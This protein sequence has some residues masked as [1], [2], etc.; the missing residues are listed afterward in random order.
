MPGSDAD[1]TLRSATL[2]V[3]VDRDEAEPGAGEARPRGD[4]AG[5]TTAERR[6]GA[7][8]DAGSGAAPG[9]VIARRYRLVEPLGAGAH[10]EVWTAEDL[11]LGRLVALKWLRRS[12]GAI[13]A[14]VRRE[15]AA[16][17]MLRVPGVVQL[18]DEGVEGDRAFLVMERVEGTPFPGGVAPDAAPPSRRAWADVAAPALAL[19]EVLAR[20]HAAG[21]VHRD[22]KP[23]NVL[24]DAEGRPTV[25]DFG[26]SLWSAPGAR[27]TEA[28]QVLGTPLYL[29]PEQLVGAAVDGRADLYA[30]GMMLY[31]ALTGRVPHEADDVR[32]L[33][34]AR[35]SW[36]AVPIQEVDPGIPAPLAEV[37]NRLLARRPEDRFRSA[38][39]VLIALRGGKVPRRHGPELPRLGGPAPLR[40]V[41]EAARARRP[42]DVVGP[43]GAGRSRCLR[44]AGE[45][46]E[47]AGLR[48]VWL[49]SSRAPLGSLHALLGAMDEQ[50]A[51]RLEDVTAWAAG[52]LRQALD[53]GVVIVADDADRLDPWSAAILERCR[54]GGGAL[55]R[56]FSGAAAGAA[57][58]DVVAL[59]PLDEAALRP[60]FAG[61]D[62]LFHL[63]EDAART[64]WERTEGFPARVEAELTL[65]LRLGLA[66]WDGATL[67]VE[68]EALDPLR[69]GLRETT[70]A[71][72]G[73]VLEEEPHLGE[74]LRWLAVA[75]HQL[76]LEQLAAAM[77]R[78]LW[79]VEAECEELVRRGVARRLSGDRVEPLGQV[80]VTWPV[81]R[82]IKA[83]R[84]IAGVLR[85]G[86]EGRL[87]H[88]LAA[89]EE[90]S[91]AREAIE[92]ARVRA[93]AGM[94]GQAAAALGEALLVAR[95]Q[96]GEASLGAELGIL[97][98]WVKI[99]FAEGTPRAMDRVLYELSRAAA[100]G[101]EVVRLEL[102]V[103]AALSGMG[104]RGELARELADG[105]AP[106][107][108]AELERRRHGVR[109]AAAARRAS[110]LM[111]GQALVEVDAWAERDEHPMARLCLVEGRARLRYVEGRFDEAA[112]LHVEAAASE[113][114]QTGRIAA[115]LSSASA[116]LEAFRH[117]EAAARA[118]AARDLAARCRNP[119]WEG[120]AEW[121]LRSALYRMGET[122]DPDL[123]L[124][125]ATV[126][127]GVPQLEALVCLTEAA[128]A[129]RAE[130]AAVAA[131]LAGRAAGLWRGMDRASG[132]LLSRCLALAA[133]VRA[134]EG[135]VEELA[136]AARA[137]RVPGIGLQALGLLGRA[138]PEA[139]GGLRGGARRA[140]GGDPAGAVGRADGC[141][142]GRGGVRGGGRGGDDV[143]G[144]AAA[145]RWRGGAGGGRG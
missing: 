114:W 45:A 136:E 87:F 40:A 122:G 111:L 32:A 70:P 142:V 35:L 81:A 47:Q 77:E 71:A 55:V 51:R 25:L 135:E 20:V 97:S 88:L 110:P 61:P 145:C 68:R 95:R 37:I 5:A 4:G 93:S 103:Q 66:R 12:A 118:E 100:R 99:A 80:D 116:L 109:I 14:R 62:R 46:L 137:C 74:L 42:V 124:V 28:G 15:V 73:Q 33:L 131:D 129:Y 133:G 106:F 91:A 92:V 21:I 44:D 6:D 86:Q 141:V 126:R 43:P 11:V 120:R 10:G 75:G 17:R 49:L 85:P 41:V 119:Y 82:R 76:D 143:A 144:A 27:L 117:R 36:P 23:D 9:Q 94:L 125:E 50:S 53:D 16:L 132:A 79:K 26:I 104:P 64:L 98:A 140:G 54:A 128:V 134:D 19:F 107:E 139:R 130:Q 67:A 112:A 78:P 22:L 115:M 24:V 8:A 69:A 29:A 31:R 30:A 48:V 59:G 34:R 90:L 38:A 60:L 72:E 127:V 18:V 89:D 123:E 3:E 84:A 113:P 96:A 2:P 121:L 7:D 58:V 65:W 102:L 83:H 57:R 52:Q 101:P 13:S 138:A 63:R 56:S 108:D 39:E 105:I 1:L